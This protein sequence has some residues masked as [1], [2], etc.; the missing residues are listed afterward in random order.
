[1]TLIDDYLQLLE[2]LYRPKSWQPEKGVEVGSYYDNV[3]LASRL[4]PNPSGDVEIDEVQ[5]DKQQTE[6]LKWSVTKPKTIVEKGE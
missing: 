4:P 1:M 2:F 5:A 6:P 3:G